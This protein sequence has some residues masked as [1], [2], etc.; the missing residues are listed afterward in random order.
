MIVNLTGTCSITVYGGTQPS[1]ATVASNWTS[2]NSNFLCHFSAITPTQPNADSLTA[3]PQSLQFSS[4][5]TNTAS[6]TG[7]AT[8]C[9]IWSHSV[10]TITAASLVGA[11]IP[12]TMF[13]VADVS[14]IS[15]TGVVKLLSTSITSGSS[16]SVADFQIIAGGGV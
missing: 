1:A 6:N 7:T 3:Y 2:Y 5:S 4:S 13:L 8:W 12:T 15:G 16:Y 14:D 10:A 9:I 11:T